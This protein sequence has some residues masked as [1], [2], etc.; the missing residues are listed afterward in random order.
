[1]ILQKTGFYEEWLKFTISQS[2]VECDFF[3]LKEKPVTEFFG[4]FSKE[5]LIAF[6]E[7]ASGSILAFYSKE[8]NSSV[9]EAAVGWLDSEGS[10][11]III[12]NSLKEFLSILPYGMGFIYSVASLIEGNLGNPEILSIAKE[13]FSKSTSELIQESKQ[14]FLN[15]EELIFWLTSKNIEISNDPVKVIVDAHEKNNDLTSWIAENLT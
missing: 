13:K 4:D 3:D 12:S 2:I 5:R 8:D 10:P 11:C 14:R 7:H 9:E 1:M 15:I 6:G